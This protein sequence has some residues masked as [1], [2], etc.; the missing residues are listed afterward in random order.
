MRFLKS[1]KNIILLYEYLKKIKTQIIKIRTLEIH[2]IRKLDLR[3]FELL[4]LKEYPVGVNLFKYNS[5]WT[6]TTIAKKK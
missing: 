3:E 2:W 1:C 4:I 6:Q 5:N